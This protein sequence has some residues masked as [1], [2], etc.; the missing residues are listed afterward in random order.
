MKHN[1]KIATI[2]LML[3]MFFLPF[4]YDAL[5]MLIMKWT[6]SYWV[7]DA[8]FYIISAFFL[9]FYF[10][11]SD[12]NPFDHFREKFETLKR[13]FQIFTGWNEQ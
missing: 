13:R 9:G 11:C 12:I 8:I 2:C 4:G 5:F 6:G 10:Y 1:K 3:S 7:T